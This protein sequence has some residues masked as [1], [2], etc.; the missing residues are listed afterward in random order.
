MPTDGA[1]RGIALGLERLDLSAQGRHGEH[2]AG[3]TAALEDADLDF[4]LIAPTVV[5]GGIVCFE[6]LD[7]PSLDLD[8]D[9]N[10]GGG[11]SSPRDERN[12]KG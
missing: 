1:T 8:C 9:P 12:E 5:L 6:A 4:R 11:I 3:E 2:R 10:R 7:L